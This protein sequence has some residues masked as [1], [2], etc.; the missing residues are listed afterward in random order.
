MLLNLTSYFENVMKKI[1]LFIILLIRVSSSHGQCVEPTLS[2]TLN[3][4]I[5]SDNF[6]GLS[7]ATSPSS[8]AQA[9][10]YNIVS[11]TIDK[12]L[13]P[14]AINAA[15]PAIGVN[16]SYLA[17][18]RFVNVTDSQK[19]VVYLVEPVSSS[20]CVGKAA[21][22]TV[23][24]VPEPVVSSVLNRTI[25]S[26][27][28]TGL[29]LATN[30]TSTSAVS[31]NIISMVVS[32]GLVPGSNNA[33]IPIN[34]V[35]SNYLNG[36]AFINVMAVPEVVSYTV[37]PISASACQGT[38]QVITLIVNPEPSMSISLDKTVCSTSAIDL[39]LTT[40]ATSVSAQNYSVV[41][42][43]IQ[44]GLIKGSANAFVPASSVSSSYLSN[45]TYDNPTSTNLS[46]KYKIVPVSVS[47]CLGPEKEIQ[48]EVIPQL[49]KPSVSVEFLNSGFYSLTS[50]L[51]SNNQW[52]LDGVLIPLENNQNYVA[53]KSGSYSVQQ[54]NNT[55]K[56]EMSDEI[57][58]I[59]TGD[60]DLDQIGL[61]LY[62]NP[63]SE[64]LIIENKSSKSGR[65][66][67]LEI[68]D[69][70]GRL[71]HTLPTS[72]QEFIIIDVRD[73]SVGLYLLKAKVDSNWITIK[74]F[75]K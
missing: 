26:R 71:M 22:V 57:D 55:C 18:D 67:A 2:S 16:P 47:G 5:C 28:V 45:D 56:G 35:S 49:K 34:G 17:N 29:T 7:L 74:F 75:K 32:P 48:V 62:P 23:F 3:S 33:T 24:V 65:F 73:Y 60:I 19:K 11:R 59:V 66:E 42:S 6:F 4:T 8:L 54:I 40:N 52:F 36:D 51:P 68:Y 46:V 30:G 12:D 20:G 58:L 64:F 53:T 13:I 61:T 39:V 37:V 50:N 70:F 25:C 63:T 27:D 72:N 14:S 1:F 38:S 21:E 44:N 41:A 69:T 9:A 31:Y 43:S 10:S 15:V